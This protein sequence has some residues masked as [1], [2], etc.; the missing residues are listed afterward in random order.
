MFWDENEGMMRDV[1]DLDVTT[2]T[3]KLYASGGYTTMG[4]FTPEDFE[5]RLHCFA[6][7]H[8]KY[9]LPIYD[10]LIVRINGNQFAEVYKNWKEFLD[11]RLLMHDKN[12]WVDL[13]HFEPKELEIVGDIY[14][15]EELL[16]QQAVS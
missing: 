2:R 9:G 13:A 11:F 1:V 6:H 10:G 14:H 15:H 5:S 7:K 12:V 3:V 4:G 16:S 8:D